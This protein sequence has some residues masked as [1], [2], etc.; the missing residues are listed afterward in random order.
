MSD[1][2]WFDQQAVAAGVAE[3]S[4]LHR[5]AGHHERMGVTLAEVPGQGY[6]TLRGNAQDD[7][8]RSGVTTA[9]GI[10]L[11]TKPLTLVQD[12][13]LSLQWVS[14]DEW[15]IVCPGDQCFALET[16]LREQL[17]GHFAVVNVSGG[18]TMIRLSG[19][20]ALDVLYQSTG[21][22]V[23]PRHFGVGKA[24]STT[25]AKATMTLRRPS[26]EGWELI[27]R[28]SFADYCWRWLVGVSE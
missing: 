17:T 3:Q 6:L 20:R 14:P 23:H 21:Y 22:D 5:H 2:V 8:F 11:P 15:L 4:S 19:E 16:A 13:R 26:E 9:L 25:L 1:A 7:A 12:D 18:F 24:V 28:R 10:E 27:V